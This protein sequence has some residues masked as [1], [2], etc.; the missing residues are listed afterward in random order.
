[1]KALARN[2]LAKYFILLTMRLVKAYIL[3]SIPSFVNSFGIFG[4][5]F[6]M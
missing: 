6:L 4:G 3:S 2:V 1:M 5:G